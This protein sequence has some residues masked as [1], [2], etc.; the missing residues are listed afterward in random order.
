MKIFIKPYKA[1][2]KSVKA[3][4]AGL[5]EVGIDAKTIRT[6]N[7]KY[8]HD[9][10][11]HT[12]INWGNGTCPN[13]DNM[14]NSAGAVVDATNKVDTFKLLSGKDVRIVPAF[15]SKED[16]TKFMQGAD[17]R[18]VYCRTL[19]NAS[20]GK[21]I[22]VAKTPDELVDAKLYTGGIVAEGRKE[23][24]V[25][26]FKGKVL[27]TQ[28]KRRR[29]GYKENENFSDLVRNLAGGW[30]F[31]I[32]DVEIADETKTTCI[33][34]VAALGLDFGAVDVLQTPNGKGWVLE[35][36]T[37]CGLEGTTIGKYVEAIKDYV[38]DKPE[39]VEW[40]WPQLN[41]HQKEA[42]ELNFDMPQ[43]IYRAKAAGLK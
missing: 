15:Y 13:F 17:G 10:V 14:L 25:H 37:A 4:I 28:Q 38:E 34:A 35:V 40:D 12:V 19:L 18:I 43:E 5:K 20:Q 33:N 42:V 41:A 30:I 6:K 29:N 3:L 32:K 22:V 26:V 36:N 7:S 8:V 2:S 24:R 27:H 23:F 21:G 16:A 9:P 1:G 31:G 11:N 39:P